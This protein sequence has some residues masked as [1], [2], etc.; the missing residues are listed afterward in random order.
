MCLFLIECLAC[1][2]AVNRRCNI[3]CKTARCSAVASVVL[4]ATKSPLPLKTPNTAIAQCVARRTVQRSLRIRP[5]PLTNSPYR[6]A[7]I[8]Y[9]STN[10]RPNA[11][12]AFALTAVHSC[13]SGAS[14]SPNLRSSPSVRLTATRTRGPSATSSWRRKR[15]GTGSRTHYLSSKFIRVAS[16]LTTRLPCDGPQHQTVTYRHI[17]GLMQ[18]PTLIDSIGYR[19]NF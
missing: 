13:S 12:S 18:A 1:D 7:R 14:T 4:F 15:L 2:G 11:E 19:S 5:S 9:R 8:S 3:T 6:L 17:A 16:R 10:R